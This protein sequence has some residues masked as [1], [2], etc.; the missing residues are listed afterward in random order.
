MATVG[1][2]NS[3]AAREIRIAI[4]PLLAINIF[5]II[6]QTSCF[7]CGQ[8]NYAKGLPR[9]AVLWGC[10]DN[11]V[12]YWIVILRLRI[13][14]SLPW[15]LRIALPVTCATGILISCVPAWTLNSFKNNF[16]PAISLTET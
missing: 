2:F 4:S 12:T 1:I 10:K 5:L 8:Y 6:I 7:P 14:P 11:V 16:L 13:N 3:V 9:K 15:M